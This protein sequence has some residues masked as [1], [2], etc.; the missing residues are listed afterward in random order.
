MAKLKNVG[1]P[2]I[3]GPVDQTATKVLKLRNMGWTFKS[4]SKRLRI[5]ESYAH[6]LTKKYYL[7]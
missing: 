6:Q 5:S 2:P 1:R 4:I 3:H 7:T